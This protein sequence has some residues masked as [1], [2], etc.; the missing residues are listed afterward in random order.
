MDCHS[1]KLVPPILPAA[2][3]A[4]ARPPAP[5]V[6]ESLKEHLTPDQFHQLQQLQAH[7]EASKEAQAPIDRGALRMQ[8]GKPIPLPFDCEETGQ[9]R[10]SSLTI[11]SFLSRYHVL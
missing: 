4:T 9:D 10:V 8:P 2:A 1:T 5:P 6:E 7:L 11:S 3:A